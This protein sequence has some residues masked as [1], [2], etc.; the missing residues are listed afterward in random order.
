MA[1]GDPLDRATAMLIFDDSDI[2]Y[3]LQHKLVATGEVLMCHGQPSLLRF[4]S[5]LE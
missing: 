5:V 3:W 1:S 4:A 2:A